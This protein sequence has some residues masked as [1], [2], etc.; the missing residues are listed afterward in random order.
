MKFGSTV[1]GLQIQTLALGTNPR[2]S[3]GSSPATATFRSTSMSSSVDVFAYTSVMQHSPFS[4]TER[5]LNNDTALAAKLSPRCGQDPNPI[6]LEPSPTLS[7]PT[8]TKKSAGRSNTAAKL[9]KSLMVFVF[10]LLF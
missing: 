2:M 3:D 5:F 8:S 6:A 4:P 7:R 1:H 9:S 10:L